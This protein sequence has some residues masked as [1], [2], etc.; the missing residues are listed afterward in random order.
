[1][2]FLAFGLCLGTTCTVAS[3]DE[4]MKETAFSLSC[5]SE[6][7]CRAEVASQF[8]RIV[9]ED[10]KVIFNALSDEFLDI[11]KIPPCSNSTECGESSEVRNKL[12]KWARVP[13]KFNHSFISRISRLIVG[14]ACKKIF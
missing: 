5:D 1:M 8:E 7:S 11:V 4:F 6:V 2:L 14:L 9:P 3:C 12:N 10:A 13:V